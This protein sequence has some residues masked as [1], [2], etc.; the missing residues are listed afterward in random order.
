MK[1]FVFSD[2]YINSQPE[3]RG[4]CCYI[5]DAFIE[6]LKMSLK[7]IRYISPEVSIMLDKNFLLSF[8]RN[9]EQLPSSKNTYSK[10]IIGKMHHSYPQRTRLLKGPPRID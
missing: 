6:S 9:A 2:C 5:E 7:P 3:I 8:V 10:S 4:A 1:H